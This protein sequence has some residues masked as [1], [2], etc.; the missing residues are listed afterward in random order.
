MYIN[1]TIQLVFV[2][3]IL[4]ENS[5]S[6]QMSYFL[7]FSKLVTMVESN[8]NDILMELRRL[9]QPYEGGVGVEYPLEEW[10]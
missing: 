5:P 3:V 7:C 8:W 1:I 6:V 4:Q 10:N 9:Y 2:R